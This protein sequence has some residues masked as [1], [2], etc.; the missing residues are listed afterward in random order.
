MRQ[1]RVPGTSGRSKTRAKHP[2]CMRA[3]PAP[4][5]SNKIGSLTKHLDALL[6]R[7]DTHASQ[8]QGVFGRETCPTTRR[9]QHIHHSA[10]WHHPSHPPARLVATAAS[11]GPGSSRASAATQGRTPVDQAKADS[12]SQRLSGN[13]QTA[14]AAAQ[15]VFFV[16]PRSH[17]TCAAKQHGGFV[18][19]KNMHSRAGLCIPDATLPQEIHLHGRGRHQP[20]LTAVCRLARS[21]LP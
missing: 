14:V 12:R 19:H 17:H 21:V 1:R 9:P 13:R 6:R 4:P 7:P 5:H 18:P 2:S 3:C 15:L 10:R 11:T 16:G 8:S 20:T